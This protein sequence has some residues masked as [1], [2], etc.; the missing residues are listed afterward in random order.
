MTTTK[1]T[2]ATVE[3]IGVD[4]AR[5]HL[6]GLADGETDEDLAALITDA[7]TACEDRLQRSIMPTTWLLTRDTF[8]GLPGIVQGMSGL[9][10]YERASQMRVPNALQL[11]KPPVTAV[12][13]VK[14]VDASGVLQTLDPTQYLVDFKKEPAEITPAYGL[15]WPLTRVQAGAVTVQYTA[16]WAT[17]ALVPAPIKRWIKMAMTDLYENRGRSSDRPVVPQDFADELLDPYAIQV[18]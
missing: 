2:D 9:T 3:P 6:R 5:R 18:I 11:H 8:P 10:G 4:E 7:R 1:V 17:A 14:Y 15:A 12:A 13:W 16:G